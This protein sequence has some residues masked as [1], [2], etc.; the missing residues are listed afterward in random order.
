MKEELIDDKLEVINKAFKLILPVLARY[1]GK[2]LIEKDRNNW[3]RKNVLNK[4][5]DENTIRKLPKEGSDDDCIESLDVPACLNI[6]EC[7]WL[8]VFRDKMDDRQRTWAHALRDIRNYYE[9]HY[10]IKTLT[11]TSVEDIS[12]ELAIMIRFIRHID[13][14]VADHISEMK[15]IFENEFRDENSSIINYKPKISTSRDY[16][17]YIFNEEILN[18]R[19]LVLAVINKYIRDNP[20]N[21]LET[22]QNIFN[23]N[24]VD[25]YDN[26]QKNTDGKRHFFDDAINLNNGQRIV[27]CNQWGKDNIPQFIKKANELGYKIIKKED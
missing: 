12:L 13:T 25:S 22:L 5:K 16:S 11:T 20:N 3:W 27:V 6:I 8:D 21:T 18:K 7:N 17:L 2:I 1:I 15:R 26:A 14:Y 4:L 9:A 24:I 23:K 10:T 19:Q